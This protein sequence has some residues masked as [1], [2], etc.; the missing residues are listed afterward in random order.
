MR[1]CAT[2]AGHISV[3]MALRGK[4]SNLWRRRLFVSLLRNA[5]TMLT[6]RL[7]RSVAAVVQPAAVLPRATTMTMVTKATPIHRRTMT[8][9]NR[10]AESVTQNIELPQRIVTS[11]RQLQAPCL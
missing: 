1:Y 11:A 9:T 3:I 4:L 2:R 6:A 7:L 8:M 10:I 5:K